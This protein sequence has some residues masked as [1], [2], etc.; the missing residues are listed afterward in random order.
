MLLTATK[1]PVID[2][3]LKNKEFSV[4]GGVLKGIVDKTLVREYATV[5]V[6]KY[7]SS[8]LT[9]NMPYYCPISRLFARVKRHLYVLYI[10]YS[11]VCR[12]DFFLQKFIKDAKSNVELLLR[13]G[14]DPNIADIKGQTALHII[15]CSR[16]LTID[17]NEILKLILQIMENMLRILNINA[18]DEFGH[19][20]LFYAVTR[21]LPNMFISLVHYGADLSNLVFPREN[22]FEVRLISQYNLGFAKLRMI[23]DLKRKKLR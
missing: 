17:D 23:T 8:L 11:R 22:N 14:A 4:I 7:F 1:W 10:T 3:K 15:C 6:S 2:E 12:Q 9:V 18:I 13:R 5:V 19:T 21:I 16:T 20:P